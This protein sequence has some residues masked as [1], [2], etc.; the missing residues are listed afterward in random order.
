MML[1]WWNEETYGLFDQN[2]WEASGDYLEKQGLFNVVV[3]I[4]KS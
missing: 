4:L 3:I 1:F 2:H